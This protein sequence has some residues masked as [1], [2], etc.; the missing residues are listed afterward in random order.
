M[1]PFLH[2]FIFPTDHSRATKEHDLLQ[3]PFPFGVTQHFYECLLE[4]NND[5]FSSLANFQLTVLPGIVKN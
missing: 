5:L 1:T 3:T 2:D 4:E